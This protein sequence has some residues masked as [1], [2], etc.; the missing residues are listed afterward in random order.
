MET[1]VRSGMEKRS[2]QGCKQRSDQGCKHRSGQVR[3]K[4]QYIIVKY[5]AINSVLRLENS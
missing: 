1:K 4:T 5:C 2:G 3:F